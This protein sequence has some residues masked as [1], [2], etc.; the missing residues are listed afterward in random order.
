M[1]AL[2]AL[3]ILG[4]L[5]LNVDRAILSENDR[6]N[7]GEFGITALSLAQS[8]VEEAMGK[9]F[10]ARPETSIL[11]EI[12]T[13]TALTSPDSL[14]RGPTERYRYGTDDFND[15]DDYN[16]LFLVYKSDNPN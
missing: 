5:A 9:Y 15:F 16:N 2:L 7:R 8:L 6:V 1:F 13:T 12:S 3:S 4:Y 11:G 10:D 14:G